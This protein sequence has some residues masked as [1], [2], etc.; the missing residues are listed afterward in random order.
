[1]NDRIT[2]A[3]CDDEK[4]IRDQ[5]VK[6]CEKQLNGK[7]ITCSVMSFKNGDELLQT[8]KEE[9]LYIDLII[10]DIKMPGKD[11]I[12]IKQI[13]SNDI[14]VGSIAF[15]TSHISVMQ[16]AFGLKVIGFVE[17]PITE[18]VL[19]NWINMIYERVTK[20]TYI[21]IKKNVKVR[22]I[23]IKYIESDGNYSRIILDDGSESELMRES[24]SKWEE[25]LDSSFIRCHKSYIVNMRFISS[26]K[27]SKISLNSGESISI[28]RKYY[29][30]FKEKY[31]N[32]LMKEVKGRLGWRN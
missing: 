30:D 13:L 21:D 6:I 7:E 8:I 11:G 27:Y 22:S 3:V 14:H 23:D 5:I 28:G 16:E 1:M 15:V 17:K 2:V 29:P 26:I 19:T 32:Y 9:N 18:T 10:L 4:I 25:R 24:I 12:E 31:N 20:I